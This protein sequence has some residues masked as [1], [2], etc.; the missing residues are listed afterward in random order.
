M[1][2]IIVNEIYPHIKD[3]LDEYKPLSSQP[4]V[5]FSSSSSSSVPIYNDLYPSI[6]HLIKPTT[7]RFNRLLTDTK[8]DKLAG[9]F[10]TGKQLDKRRLYKFRLGETRLFQRKIEAST[11]DYVVSL[12]IDESGSM[13]DDFKNKNAVKTAI[14]FSHVLYNLKIPFSLTG[15]NELIK[16]YKK[17][18]QTFSPFTKQTNK[19]F[20][21][22]YENTYGEGH[23]WNNDGEAI[24]QVA[25]QLLEF[26]SKKLM[27]II[28]DGEPAP[29]PESRKYEINQEIK[30]AE[31]QGIE[32]IGFGI[33]AGCSSVPNYYRNHV[34]VQKVEE[35]PEALISSLRNKLKK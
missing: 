13:T 8:F 3:L 26:K 23:H 15:F 24:N 1:L 29:S 12:V 16:H 25:K 32:I 20:Q 9:K 34:L 2:K 28:S 4:M 21:S 33:G 30:K 6:K 10:R 18:N 17:P 11:K 14:L 7:N 5:A 22:M 19:I 27:L 31:K 35:L